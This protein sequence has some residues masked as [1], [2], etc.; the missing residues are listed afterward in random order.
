LAGG[1]LK[2][3]AG[4]TA[5]YGL[6]N[7]VGRFLNYLLVP[8]HTLIFVDPSYY[9]VITV[10][11]AYASMLMI[12]LSY[13]TETTYFRFIQ[14]HEEG[15][16]FGSLWASLT[17]TGLAFIAFAFYY[18]NGIAT[19]IG[20]PESGHYVKVF[21]LILI[22]DSLSALAL[23]R[24]RQFEK[25]KQFALINISGILINVGLNLVIIYVFFP[26]ASNNP[27]WLY[28][29]YFKDSNSLIFLIFLA[30]LAQAIIKLITASWVA[31]KSNLIH[32]RWNI[33]PKF[34][35]YGGTIALIGMLGI[36]NETADRIFLKEILGEMH[37]DS[38]ADL[39]VG[40]YGANYKLAMLV[41]IFVQA[42]RFAAEPLF[43]KSAGKDNKK[44][45]LGTV[46]NYFTA[47]VLLITLVI[48]LNLDYFKFFI[49]NESYYPG[50]VV[51]PI[52][53]LANVFLGISINLSIWYKMSKK[54]HMGIY[55][56]IVGAFITIGGNFL[57]ISSY[58]YLASAYS[59]LACYA[60][61][62]ILSYF[63]G[64]K[65]FPIPYQIKKIG[66]LF[67]TSG[68]LYMGLSAIIL[69]SNVAQ[70]AFRNLGI[71][72][73][74]LMAYKVAKSKRLA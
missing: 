46:L 50:L 62:C 37:G 60:S 22:F 26:Y 54:T 61:I 44:E 52:L 65:H 5:I 67:L 31:V 20:Y 14:T 16:V 69:E 3:L 25:A 55:L 49:R 12:A 39:Q 10:M 74:A 18:S 58:G 71:I 63:M 24:L 64:K 15:K 51:V 40:I 66:L 27:E 28:A 73:F 43:F 21:A 29:P 7:I 30:N 2:K 70:F 57:F 48:S 72:L 38:Y 68:L 4:Q 6:P 45:L 11:Y 42:F 53:L 33:L 13:G 23:A 1:V 8:L 34:W 36:L 47:F 19:V 56:A 59:T 9:G 32:F 17:I 41:T 35:K